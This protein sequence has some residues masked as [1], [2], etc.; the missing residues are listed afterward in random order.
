MRNVLF[1]FCILVGTAYL[2]FAALFQQPS[3]I[4]IAIPFIIA[5]IILYSIKKIEERLGYLILAGT[6]FVFL[7]SRTYS[8]VMSGQKLEQYF[9]DADVY[10]SLFY[11]TISLV[12]LLIGEMIFSSSRGV[13]IGNLSFGSKSILM[14]ME[15]TEKN[16]RYIRICKYLFYI[17]A[18]CQVIVLMYRIV[19]VS[20]VGYVGSYLEMNNTAASIPGIISKLADFYL[21][22]FIIMLALLPEYGIIKNCIYIFVFI[23]FLSLFTGARNGFFIPV[24]FLVWYFFYRRNCGVDS[25]RNNYRRFKRSYLLWAYLGITLIGIIGQIRVDRPIDASI[26][27][28]ITVV[29]ENLGGSNLVLLRTF[30]IEEQI[31][32]A[33]RMKFIFGPILNFLDNNIVSRIFVGTKIDPYNSI[34][35]ALN[36]KNFGSFLTYTYDQAFYLTGGGYGSS[37]IAEAYVAGK[38]TGVVLISLLYSF[39]LS[40]PQKVRYNNWIFRTILFLMIYWLFYVPRDAALY[41]ITSGLNVTNLFVIFLV[42]VYGKRKV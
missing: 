21:I 24:V 29:A 14:P 20:T 16:F 28:P 3:D 35:Y 4:L 10:K 7:L 23:S 39:V 42:W 13:R 36:G 12:S 6:I 5:A 17:G 40:L 26:F 27:N 32:D 41:F 31:S 25:D 22:A 37:Y 9:S 30:N 18:V 15:N 34:A 19:L 33:D 1:L 38:T 11:I 2:A 8:R